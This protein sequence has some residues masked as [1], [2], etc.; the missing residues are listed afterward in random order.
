MHYLCGHSTEPTL[1]PLW[2]LKY[3]TID[4]EAVGSLAKYLVHDAAYDACHQSFIA[5]STYDTIMLREHLEAA[6][7]ALCQYL[8]HE[9]HAL[10]L[11]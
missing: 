10:N 11:L 1:T 8:I 7:V 5:L 3:L 9:Y 6:I 4:I 2:N